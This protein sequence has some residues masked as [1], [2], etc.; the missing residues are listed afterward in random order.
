M[1]R[2]EQY[3]NI[4]LIARFFRWQDAYSGKLNFSEK[5]NNKCSGDEVDENSTVINR[6]KIP[7][8]KASMEFVKRLVLDAGRV[9]NTSIPSK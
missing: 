3:G 9:L 1:I 6:K 4:L 5:L 8:V 7:V 2:F